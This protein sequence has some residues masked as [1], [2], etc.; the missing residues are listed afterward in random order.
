M[1]RRSHASLNQSSPLFLL[2][3]GYQTILLRIGCGGL[4]RR[5]GAGFRAVGNRFSH[6][7]GGGQLDSKVHGHKKFGAAVAAPQPGMLRFEF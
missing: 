7:L 6:T 5:Y 1:P 3:L 4:V 2:R